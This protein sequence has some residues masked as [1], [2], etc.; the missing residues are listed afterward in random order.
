MV[1]LIHMA[2]VAVL[3]MMAMGL[4][5]MADPHLTMATLVVPL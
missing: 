4:D 1:R 3:V 5:V 2:A